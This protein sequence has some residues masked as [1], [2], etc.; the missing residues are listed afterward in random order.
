MVGNKYVLK[1]VCLDE[2]VCPQLSLA[3]CNEEALEL[4]KLCKYSE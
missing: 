3:G 4:G 2:S 1:G